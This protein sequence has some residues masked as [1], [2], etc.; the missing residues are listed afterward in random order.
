MDH[1]DPHYRKINSSLHYALWKYLGDDA[2]SVWAMLSAPDPSIDVKPSM[3]NLMEMWCALILQT[4]PIRVLSKYIPG[5]SLSSRAGCHLNIASPLVQSFQSTQAGHE[6][7]LYKSKDP[8]IRRYYM[9]CKSDYNQLKY[10]PDPILREYW[11]NNK[12]KAL[13][14][15]TAVRW[16]SIR[17][18]ALNGM[19]VKV[20]DRGGRFCIGPCKFCL[21]RDIVKAAEGKPVFVQCTLTE[22]PDTKC[23]AKESST[24]DDAARLVI[25]IRGTRPDGTGFARIA[26]A[27]GKSI[28][29][30]CNT[31]FDILVGRSQAESRAL[32]GRYYKSLGTWIRS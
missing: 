10:S 18:N 28:V 30:T 12:R 3:L 19:E 17:T 5:I 21:G 1:Q 32:P 9:Q 15:Q 29:G 25:R 26:R 6:G 11:Y 27:G 31:L 23:Y 24:S 20:Y 13:A 14:A 2:N 16:A 4:L 7:D 22:E 8:Q